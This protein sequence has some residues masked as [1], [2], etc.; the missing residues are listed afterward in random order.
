VYRLHSID[1]PRFRLYSQVWIRYNHFVMSA[2]TLGL[3]AK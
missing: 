1:H 2:T 3:T